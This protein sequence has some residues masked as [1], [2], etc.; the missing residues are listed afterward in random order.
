V[1]RKIVRRKEEEHSNNN[2]NKNA[3]LKRACKKALGCYV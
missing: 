1:G 3:H 2:S